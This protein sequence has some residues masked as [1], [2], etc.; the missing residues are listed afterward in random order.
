MALPKPIR[1]FRNILYFASIGE[2]RLSDIIHGFLI[3]LIDIYDPQG[4]KKSVSRDKKISMV[5]I[6]VYDCKICIG[7]DNNENTD[8]T[9]TLTH[10]KSNI[11]ESHN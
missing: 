4:N 7:V 6:N 11:L 1:R 9:D 10:S 5:I 2:L 8:G 3:F